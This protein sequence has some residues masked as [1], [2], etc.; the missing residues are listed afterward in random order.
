MSAVVGAVR[1]ILG[2]DSAAFTK[3]MSDAQR[4]LQNAGKQMQAIGRQ[5]S[6]RVTAPIVGFGALTLRAAGNF[7]AAMNQVSAVS[8]ATGDEM[9][10]LSDQARQLGATTQYTAAQAG[11]AM[12]FLAMAGMEAIDILDAM[13]D[14]L[15]LAAAAQL[16][17]A[18]AADIVTN[19][20]AGYNMDVEQLGRATDVL[21]KSFTSANTDLSDLAEAMKYAGPVAQAAGVQFEETAAAL[22]LMGNAGIQGSMAGTSLRGAISRILNPTSAMAD[23]M[24]EA[25]LSFTDAQGRLLPLADIIEELE[26]HADNAGLFMQLFGQRAGPAMAA[27]VT[28]GS[29]AVRELTGEL[30]NS[31]GTAAEVAAV[32]M[33]GF[34]GAMRQLAAAFEALQL[35]IADAGL[36]QWASDAANALAGFLQELSQTNPE[37]LRMGT[38]V[39]G[40][41]A[42]IGPLLVVLGTLATAVAAVSAPV[43]LVI[44]GIAALTAAIIAFW[45]EISHLASVVAEFVSGAWQSFV[46]AM[47]SFGTHL[48][49]VRQDIRA[50]AAQIPE[51]FAE[52][53]GRML[54]IGVDIIQGL[55]N[56]I[57]S[58]W[59]EF[60]GWAS[61]LGDQVAGFFTNPLQIFS[62]S[63]VMHGVGVNVMEGLQNGMDSMSSQVEQTAKNIA[64]VVTRAFQGLISGSM[65]VGEAIS[66]V[67]QQLGQMFLTQGFQAL[68]GLG[69]GGG[70]IGGLFSGIGNILGFARGG[71]IMP[72]GAGGIDSQLVMFRKS[73]NERVDITKP[74]QTLTSG[75]SGPSELNFNITVSGARGNSEVRQMVEE[76]MDSALQ[77]VRQ[78]LPDWVANPRV[79]FV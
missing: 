9:Q 70:G 30:E 52:L 73:P 42:A 29:D 58:K 64:D 76:G 75:D 37:M 72:G 22:S 56:G 32:Q 49:A 44:V 79:K 25:G 43:A 74:G 60:T 36:L 18:R 13:P 53:P 34:N 14:T 11:D 27:L 28:Q 48:E 19:I 47:D 65:T 10:A 23:A 6:V 15:Q 40:V 12:G 45:P 77:T 3:G 20:L 8:G 21:V 39:A 38:I 66:S 61:G 69:G 33:Q 68:F 78:H 17:M 41:A 50:F 31:V 35:A 67:M 5:M 26:P 62:P 59:G 7:E 55:W 1:V 63:R 16:D 54:Q 57:Q 51:F 4:H 2:L 24:R 46:D 71:T